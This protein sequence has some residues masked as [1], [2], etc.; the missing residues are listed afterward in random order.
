MAEVER[1]V[2][3]EVEKLVGGL[4]EEVSEHALWGKRRHTRS[5]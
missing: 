1:A 5:P 2:Q 3:G 4:G